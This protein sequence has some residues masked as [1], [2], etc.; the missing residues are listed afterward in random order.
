MIDLTPGQKAGFLTVTADEPVTISVG[1]SG[2]VY[3]YQG[4]DP[5]DE[6]EPVAVYDSVGMPHEDNVP[7]HV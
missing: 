5:N 2:L 7:I 1:P 4:T 3:V 6:S